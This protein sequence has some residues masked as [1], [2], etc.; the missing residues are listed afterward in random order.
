MKSL[1]FVVMLCIFF[2]ITYIGN[3]LSTDLVTVDE[4][5]TIRSYKDIIERKDSVLVDMYQEIPEYSTFKSAKEGSVEHEIFKITKPAVVD[6]S[7]CINF[8]NQSHVEI[9]RKLSTMTKALAC[10][11]SGTFPDRNGRMLISFDENLKLFT[12]TNL[13]SRYND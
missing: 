11:A 7:A 8:Y 4:P 3:C 2:L 10:S 1:S 6:V 13:L 5:I 9:S 12:N